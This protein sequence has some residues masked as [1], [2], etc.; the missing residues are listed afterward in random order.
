MV[1]GNGVAQQQ[2]HGAAF[3]FADEV[4]H[5]QECCAQD[6]AGGNQQGKGFPC[7]DVEAAVGE[8]ER[9]AGDSVAC[10]GGECEDDEVSD[11]F[12]GKDLVAGNGVAQQ[13]RHSAAFD[14]ADEGI[15]GEEHGDERNQ[16]DG[17]AG[18]ADDGYGQR[19]DF[20]RACRRAAEEAQ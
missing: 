4:A 7:G 5:G 17:Q 2:R 9:D 10:G 3:D 6:D 18:E 15:V 20:N 8:L 14:F 13:Q 19:I 11:E 12:S 16:E 1:A